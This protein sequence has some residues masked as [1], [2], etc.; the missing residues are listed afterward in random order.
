L[1]SGLWHGA[2]WNFVIWGGFHG[3]FLI[4]DRLF[5]LRLLEKSG[6]FISTTFTF[7]VVVMGW[8]IFRIEDI[9][10]AMSYYVKLFSFDFSKIS[11]SSNPEL[12]FIMT[13]AVLFSFITVSK[14]GL[15]LQEAVFYTRYTV[16]RKSVMLL[17]AV[18]L[19]ILSVAS[20]TTSGFN[21][22]IYFRF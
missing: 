6:K 22:F 20:I 11:F 21:P 2:S 7:L 14:H 3:L 19:L 18:T 9:P 1:V 8:V 13:V 10:T 4:L 15:K 5:L 16:S 12:F 17:L